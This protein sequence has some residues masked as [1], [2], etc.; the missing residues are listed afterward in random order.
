[1]SMP[2]TVAGRRIRGGLFDHKNSGARN[3]S[4]GPIRCLLSVC[5]CST[6]ISL[7]PATTCQISMIYLYSQHMFLCPNRSYKHMTYMLSLR[8]PKSKHNP[9]LTGG[10]GRRSDGRPTGVVRVEF[11]GQTGETSAGDLYNG[12]IE[13]ILR[14]GAPDGTGHHTK[15]A[16]R[17]NP[18]QGGWVGNLFG[19]FV[20][21][22]EYCI[23]KRWRRR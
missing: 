1:M 4:G 6:Y 5:K 21:G 15:D 9:P 7:K 19:A 23:N 12:R 13:G 8:R 14:V 11:A 10:G 16:W 18:R 3:S 17:P 20:C 2:G 22:C